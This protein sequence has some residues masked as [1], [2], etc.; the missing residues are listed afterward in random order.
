MTTNDE[1]MSAEEARAWRDD[2]VDGNREEIAK[3]CDSV[4]ALHDRLS[5]ADNVARVTKDTADELRRQ[6]D[7]AREKLAAVTAEL[8]E[9]RRLLAKA[10]R[11]ELP[12]CA[13][14]PETR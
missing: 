14:T 11:G 13:P 4:I 5:S 3:L 1:V 8:D 10:T 9:A 12:P 2:G 6:R 7:E